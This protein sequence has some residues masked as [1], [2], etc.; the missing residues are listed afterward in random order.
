MLDTSRKNA[1]MIV[2]LSSCGKAS[3]PRQ[4]TPW[5]DVRSGTRQCAYLRGG[6]VL[7]FQIRPGITRSL[8]HTKQRIQRR[9]VKVKV[10]SAI[11]VLRFSVPVPSVGHEPSDSRRS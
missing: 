1:G 11:V 5:R 8:R 2:D 4:S 10:E 3:P 7:G 9:I 6:L